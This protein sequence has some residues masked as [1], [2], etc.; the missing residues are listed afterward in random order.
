MEQHSLSSSLESLSIVFP[1]NGFKKETSGYTIE[2]DSSDDDKVNNPQPRS[3]QKRPQATHRRSNSADFAFGEYQ[4]TISASRLNISINN[5]PSPNTTHPPQHYRN[6][7]S[8]DNYPHFL[9]GSPTTYHQIHYATPS[10]TSVQI[11]SQSL[12][13]N[14]F[15]Q[16]CE[17]SQQHQHQ[18]HQPPHIPNNHDS[19]TSRSYSRSE[20]HT[21]ELQ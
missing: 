11:L 19:K 9:A 5:N 8:S 1:K 15:I 13:S 17:G 7:R 2:S 12:P 21:S 14:S 20:E 10:S 18:Q 6:S 4:P 16:Q 3:N